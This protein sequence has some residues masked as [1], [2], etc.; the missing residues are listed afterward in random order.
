LRYEIGGESAANGT[1]SEC[2]N[3][4]PLSHLHFDPRQLTDLVVPSPK[5]KCESGKSL[6]HCSE[7]LRR[8]DPARAQNPPAKRRLV[9]LPPSRFIIPSA[10][11][12]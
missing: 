3:D 9:F 2:D 4:L 12:A 1:S 10:A 8:F 6:P 7:N 5:N 11:S